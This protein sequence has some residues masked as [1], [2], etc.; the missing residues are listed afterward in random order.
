[1]AEKLGEALLDLDTNDKKFNQGVDR[2][3]RR[4]EKLGRSF[5]DTARRAVA[6]GRAMGAAAA[7]GAAAFTAGIVG[8]V[9]RLEEMRK[10]GAQVDQALKNSGNTARTSA[11]EIEAW[12]DRLEDRTGRAAEEVMAV[13]ANLASFGFGREQFYRALE[14]ADDMSAAWGGDLKQNL[15]GLSRALDDPINGM[16]ML[17]KRGVKLTEDQKELAKSFLDAG[18]KAS[19]QGV[20]FDALEA[21]VKGV[22][23]AGF[24]GLTAAIAKAQKR[25]EDAF[26]DLVQGKGDAADLR[27]T[28][29]DLANTLSSPEFIGAVMGFGRMVV[30]LINGI[31]K[32]VVDVQ[33]A[34]RK[35]NDWLAPN[36]ASI[37]EQGLKD[38]IAANQAEIDNLREQWRALPEEADAAQSQL[39]SRA[40]ALMDRN[41]SLNLAL[42]RKSMVGVAGGVG[43]ATTLPTGVDPYAGLSGG[44]D[45][46]SKKVRDL[47][48]DLEFERQIVG[49]S[50]RDQDIMNTIRQ[51]GVGVM[52]EQ[53]LEIRRLMTETAEHQDQLEQMQE[54]YQLLGNIGET[55]IEGIVDALSDSKVEGRELLSILGSA[56]RLAGQFFLNRGAQAAGGGSTLVGA[57]LGGFAG[58]FAKGGLIPSGGFGIVGEEGPELVSASSRGARVTSNSDLAGMLGG[59]AGGFS[60]QDNRTIVFEGDMDPGKLQGL[61]EQDRLA[62]RQELPGIVRYILANP[63]R[64]AVPT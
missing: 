47:I 17:S 43:G 36:D 33:S 12:A 53:G 51:A 60:Y 5:D 35:L 42:G 64:E 61:L 30:D 59:G 1:M 19:A 7:V 2:A 32:A 8:A 40:Q 25:W 16:A 28:L 14:L 37:S 48:A 50:A 56:M 21:Q 23:E 54:N 24:G 15:E 34:F 18:D 6:L 39:A 45:D 63:R 9:K 4:A 57:L 27:D 52:S 55:A 41:T 49:L 11:K 13:S 29:V 22:A 10:A 38:M 26:E 31:A 58:A 44:A 62:R 3:E 20:V 46:A